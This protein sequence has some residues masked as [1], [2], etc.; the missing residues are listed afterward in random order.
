MKILALSDTYTPKEVLLQI[1]YSN[2]IDLIITCGD[3]SL[4]DIS[5]LK[6][7]IDI[8][9]IGVYG[10]H[11]TR[12]YMEELGII[13]LH[14]KS[15]TVN[16][17]VFAGFEGCVRYKDSQFAPMYTQLEA[18]ELVKQ[19]PKADIII[20]HCPPLGINDDQNSLSHTGFAALL[21]Y[22]NQYRPKAWFHGHTHP[23]KEQ[24]LTNYKSTQIFYTDPYILVEL[25]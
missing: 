20:S 13:N 21:N 11:C 12:G 6:K 15:V 3:F 2:K 14:L 10:N 8:P 9:K 22:L 25:N 18:I 16:D 4:F 24:I 17:L 23:L 1:I 5:W 19:L 7:V